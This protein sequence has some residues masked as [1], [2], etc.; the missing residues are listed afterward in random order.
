M[1]G[2]RP[3]VWYKRLFSRAPH[4]RILANP[5]PI[6]ITTPTGDSGA[7]TGAALISWSANGVEATE[8]HIGSPKGPLFA[9]TASGDNSKAASWIANKTTFY[10]QD[11]SGG[12]PLS[13]DHT[14]AQV[15]VSLTV[16]EELRQWHALR[17]EANLLVLHD[18]LQA[19]EMADRY[20]VVGG[21]L[22]GW[23][24]EGRILTHEPQ[25]GDFGF[26]SEDRE[27][28]LASIPCLIDA[29]FEPV[30]RFRNNEGDPVAYVFEKDWANFEFFEHRRLTGAVRSWGFGSKIQES[31]T[32]EV[33][34]IYQVPAFGLSPMEFWGRT[35][36]KPD[37]HDAYLSAVY[38]DWRT[39]NYAYD[40]MKD[41][42]S[43]IDIHPW[44][45]SSNWQVSKDVPERS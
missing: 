39:P 24:R 8:V 30:R 29:G 40:F 13:P 23:A 10:L 32:I 7:P 34:I 2:A 3:A 22:I 9:R 5:N 20:F 6:V 38:G 17:L 33:E 36:R 26:F 44:T 4:G 28:F 37:D 21:L 45:G 41:D 27:K 16:A 11:V 31:E 19:G 35:W 18:A 25:D 1:P 15:A 14:L 12:K 42:L 43:V